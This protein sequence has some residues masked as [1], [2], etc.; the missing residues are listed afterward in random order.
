[1]VTVAELSAREY[2]AAA[3]AALP[4][5]ENDHAFSAEAALPELV[6]PAARSG[7]REV[8]SRAFGVLSERALAAGTPW[9]LG[10]RAR[11]QALMSESEHAEDAYTE[12]ISQ[13]QN[14]RATVDLARTHL[15]YGQWL[16]RVRRRRDARHQLRAANDMFTAMGADGFAAQAA[17]ELRAT[18]ER[19]RVPVPQTTFDLT[20]R[21]A[22]VAEL[23]GE[24]ASNNDIAAQ[25]FISPRTVEYHLG[26]VFWKLKVTSRSH[27]PPR[28][29]P[30]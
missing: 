21:E 10:L 5:I 22:R 30:K 13:L 4:V 26:K 7:T 14:S 24:G 3:A 15:L 27:L 18:G 16:R 17:T 6:E 12:S 23:A 29:A 2:D 25:L 9:A 11:C 8:A 28:P 19:V 20:P 1:M